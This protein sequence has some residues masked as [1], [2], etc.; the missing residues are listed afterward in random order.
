MQL[1]R[2][3]FLR[4]SPP[5]PAMSAPMA[6]RLADRARDPGSGDSSGRAWL[7]P[8]GDHAGRRT[9]G[10]SR[11]L[12]RRGHAAAPR[13]PRRLARPAAAWMD[14]GLLPRVRRLADARRGPRRGTEPSS[15]LRPLRR[16]L[17]RGR[18]GLPLLRQRG[19]RDA[20]LAGR[21]RAAGEPKDRDVWRVWRLS[22]VDRHAPGHASRR[23][24]ARRPGHG[25]ARHRRARAR[26]RAARR[27]GLSREGAGGRR[28]PVRRGARRECW[29]LPLDVLGIVLDRTRMTRAGRWPRAL[30]TRLVI[31]RTSPW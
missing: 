17:A 19:P 13:L 2:R 3:D 21:R 18:A 9:L 31:S 24:H 20:G 30:W 16:R 25:R 27:A 1:P 28:V 26:I 11:R 12:G 5:T 4:S 8:V 23:A 10:A 6:T 29:I 14:A 15:S 22:E 7:E